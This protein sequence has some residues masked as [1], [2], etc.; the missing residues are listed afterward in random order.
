MGGE[1]A[2]FEG[3]SYGLSYGPLLC[4]PLIMVGFVLWAPIL[5]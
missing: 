5:L 4:A 1:A 2:K 3:L